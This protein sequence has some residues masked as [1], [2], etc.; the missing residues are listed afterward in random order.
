MGEA[1]TGRGHEVLTVGRTAGDVQADVADPEQT[2]HDI[3]TEVAI[4][5]DGD[6]RL[7]VGYDEVEFLAPVHTG[8]FPEVTGTVTRIGTTSRTV[9]PE[10]R[11]V[12][13]SWYDQS[14]SG[15]APPRGAAAL[16]RGGRG[17]GGSYR[18]HP[19]RLTGHALIHWRR[20]WNSGRPAAGGRRSVGEDTT[21]HTRSCW[22]RR[23]PTAPDGPA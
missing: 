12:I 8:D 18:H 23:V 13:A 7:F 15:P 1:L 10:A 14:P 5:T 3:V 22:A 16:P 11:E 21:V 9:Q 20:P 4:T 17:V 19:L 6:E 2:A